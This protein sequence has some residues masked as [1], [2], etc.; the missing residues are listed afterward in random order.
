[1]K[2]P[3]GEK[4]TVSGCIICRLTEH[5][6]YMRRLAEVKKFLPG[7]LRREKRWG[8]LDKM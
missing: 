6:A 8:D 2:Q 4:H 7:S 5:V 1:M 3:S